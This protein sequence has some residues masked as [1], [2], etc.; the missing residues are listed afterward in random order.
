M[1]TGPPLSAVLV[2]GPTHAAAFSLSPL[3][4]FTYTPAV[5]YSGPDAF[6]YKA[7][8]GSDRLERGHGADHVAAVNDGARQ[9]RSGRADDE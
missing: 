7:N 4:S 1:P 3:G 5:N 8:D 2:S 9:H 6:T